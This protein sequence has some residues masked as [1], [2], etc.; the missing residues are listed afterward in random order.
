MST[1]FVKQATGVFALLAMM[2]GLAAF[3]PA[4]DQARPVL[5]INATGQT[6]LRFY[7][8][9]PGFNVWEEDLL[10]REVIE[11]GASARIDVANGSGRCLYDFRAELA[12]GSRLDRRQVNVCEITEYRYTA[13]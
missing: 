2:A 10:D 5:I 6:I 1:L 12:D 13:D 3:A 11:N 8:S 9:T 7:A 4:R